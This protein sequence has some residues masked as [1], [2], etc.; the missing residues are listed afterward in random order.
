VDAV[1]DSVARL[2][3]M[4]GRKAVTTNRIA[5]ARGGEHRLGVPVL[6]E[7]AVR[8]SRSQALLDRHLERME[9]LVDA[10]LRDPGKRTLA[11]RVR[12]LVEGMVAAHAVDPELHELLLTELPHR[13]DP[14]RQERVRDAYRF[15][16]A[17]ATGG[18]TSRDIERVLFVVTLMV[19]ALVHGAVFARPPR[20]SLSAATDEAVRAVLA[21]LEA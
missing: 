4:G 21:Y 3:K 15:A 1:L 20:L 9:H 16:I 19:E 7:Q 17:P 2:L 11:D 10:K 6:P 12:G 14:E 5:E 8:L 18:K 13:A